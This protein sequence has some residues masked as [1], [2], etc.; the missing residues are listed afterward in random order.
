MRSQ[1]LANV[2]KFDIGVQATAK[3]NEI[4]AVLDGAR[5]IRD[6]DANS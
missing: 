4:I 1:V 5:R 3:M 6:Q 2:P